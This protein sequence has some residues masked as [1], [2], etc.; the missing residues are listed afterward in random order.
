MFSK[1]FQ[2]RHQRPSDPSPNV[3]TL[4]SS[5]IDW[6]SY[7]H[8]CGFDQRRVPGLLEDVGNANAEI[9]VPAATELWNYLAHQA[10][11]GSSSVPAL[12]FVVE[13]LSSPHLKVKL[14]LLDILLSFSA[15][16]LTAHKERLLGADQAWL[17]VL[18]SEMCKYITVFRDL[19]GNEDSDVAGY[20]EDI[21]ENLTE[22]RIGL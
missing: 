1:L 13:R 18:G 19:A 21:L 8:P 20:S 2:R 12:P 16:A 15:V 5:A 10:N 9:A 4:E 14:E 22:L 11:V 3:K 17:H 6:G 7:S